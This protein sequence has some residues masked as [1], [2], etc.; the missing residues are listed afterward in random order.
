MTKEDLDYH[1]MV[2][3]ARVESGFFYNFVSQKHLKDSEKYF[4]GLTCK[5]FHK[6]FKIDQK[7]VNLSVKLPSSKTDRIS[8]VSSTFTS[9]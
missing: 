7:A 5:M 3:W 4:K 9:I 8:C 6:R 2:P 1:L